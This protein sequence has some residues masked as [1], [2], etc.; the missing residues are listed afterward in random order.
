[1]LDFA[2]QCDRLITHSLFNAVCSQFHRNEK[3]SVIKRDI[4]KALKTNMYD[5]AIK[6]CKTNNK[7][8]K[9]AKFLLKHKLIWLIKLI[10]KVR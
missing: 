2:S 10:S 5:K 8:L 4:I 1:M 3:Y 7:K 9:L 6:N